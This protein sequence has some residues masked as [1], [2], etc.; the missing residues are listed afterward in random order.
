MGDKEKYMEVPLVRSIEVINQIENGSYK[1]FEKIIYNDLNNYHKTKKFYAYKVKDDTMAPK[2]FKNDIIIFEK[3]DSF[4]NYDICV[5]K[6]ANEE[7]IV[8]RISTI[9]GLV[10]LEAL[11]REYN[12]TMYKEEDLNETVKIIGK[13]VTLIRNI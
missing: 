7:F 10:L 13:V 12:T 9:H 4:S 11:N 2:I 3:T 5:V 1:N 8:R 6:I